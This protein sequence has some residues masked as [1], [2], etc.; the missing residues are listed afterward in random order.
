VAKGCVRILYVWLVEVLNLWFGACLWVGP[1]CYNEF[2]GN[3]VLLKM[4]YLFLSIGPEVFTFFFHVI[5][6]IVTACLPRG[7]A[8]AQNSLDATI[9]RSVQ[10]T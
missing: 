2:Q 10:H 4:M 7:H 9:L 8:H 3:V 1:G 6:R 5:H